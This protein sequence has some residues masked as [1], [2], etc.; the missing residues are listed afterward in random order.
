MYRALRTPN[1]CKTCALGMG[2]QAGGMVNE[3]GH[4]PEVCKKSVQAMAADMQGA[5]ADR[6]VEQTSFTRMAG[7]TPREL[8]AWGRL[9]KP[10]IAGPLDTH[11]RVTTWEDALGRITRKL[12]ATDPDE[13][14][15]YV[16][17]RSSNEAGFLIQLFA[18]VYGTNNVNNCS[19]YCHQASG[20]GLTTVTG[21]GTA[22]VVLEDLERLGRGDVFFLIGA[23]PASNHPRLMT[24]LVGFKRRGG[25]VV[26]VNPLKETG[27]VRFKIPS[28]LGS[29]LFGTEIADIYVQP[30]IGGD[31]AFLTGVAKRLIEMG[32]VDR[33]FLTDHTSGWEEFRQS[34]GRVN[35]DDIVSGCGVDFETIDRVARLYGSATNAIFAWAMGITHHAHGVHNV[36]AIANLALTRGMIGRQGA[37]L[38]PIRGHSN[39]QG[40]GSVGVTPGLK[41]AVMS[42][43]ETELGVK[44]PATRGLD[45][46]G[47][48]I[49]SAEGKLKVGI[50]LGGNLFGSNPDADYAA[51]ALQ[52]LDLVVYMSTTLNTGHVHGRGKETIVLPVLARDE[53]SQATT[54][55]SMFNFVRLSDGGLSRH[56]GPKSEV[57]V[58]AD[59]AHAID[60][61]L[62]W[63][64][65]R[66][67]RSIREAISKII[68]GYRAIGDI[69]DTRQ[70]FQ[71]EGRTLHSPEFATDDGRARFHAVPLPPLRGSTG[72]LRLMT[73]RSEGQFNT[74]VY[75]EEDIY[76]GQERRDVIML[77][78]VDM[79]R[80]GLSIDQR[81]RVHGEAGTMKDI[82]VREVDIAPGNAVMYYPEANVLLTRTTDASSLTPAFKGGVVEVIPG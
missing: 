5:L 59:I 49:A 27:L 55:E 4:F 71:I 17:G 26:V 62:D 69:D 45:T 41:K 68:P 58:I 34:T 60:N 52:N 25:K 40:I 14:F 63:D 76:R 67:H 36:Q 32:A 64:A 29:L 70:E 35:W 33:P 8:E 51:R 82:L 77:S 21:S 15:F 30:H 46:M 50:S 54:Q 81:V 53:E 10:L 20:V 31:I 61:T 39:V 43:L 66:R 38:L 80:L 28:K 23:N 37:G 2:G 74:V 75:E 12:A 16:S 22:T 78:P 6:A 57:A 19:F 9:T 44:A 11:Y 47:C 72:T 24:N 65:L 48:V 3:S 42:A 7:M 1:A 56:E 13:T 73:V 18:R 79:A